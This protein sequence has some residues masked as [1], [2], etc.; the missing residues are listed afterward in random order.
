MLKRSILVTRPCYIRTQYNQL[1]F[2][3]ENEETKQVPIEDLGFLVLEHTQIRISM[4]ALVE[5]NRENVAV[6]IC[7][8][9]HLP[10]SMMLN[11]DAH[12]LQNQ[13]FKAQIEASEPLRKNLWKQTV[14]KKIL[15]QAILLEHNGILQHPLRNFSS[16]VTSGDTTNREGAAAQFYWK[17]IFGKP[18]IRKRDG[19]FPNL[20]LNY[21]YTI[22][23]A[24][25]AR[26][27]AGSGLL[28]TLGIHH[29]NKYNAFALADDIMEP[30]RPLVDEKVIQ[31]MEKYPGEQELT[32]GIK[33][34][35]L[36]IL[37]RTVYDGNIKSPLMVAL[38]RTASSLQQCF[39][40]E[41]RKINYPDLWN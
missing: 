2:R 28:N 3:F 32:K 4:P 1:I 8:E 30:F 25:V 21:G 37:T 7:D 20:F 41:R 36:S 38:Q 24:G 34:E 18:F 39:T 29:R 31:I 23:R 13:I 16:K 17:H 6:I 15:N 10:A 12:Y 22:L 5:L 26:A 11:L 40:G 9:K 19:E 14:K 27:L 35:L 33:A